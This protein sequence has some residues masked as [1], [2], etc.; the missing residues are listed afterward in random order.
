VGGNDDAIKQARKALDLDPNLLPGH[1]IL[2]QTYEVEGRL[3]EAI[4][5]YH[6][7]NEIEAT[8]SNYAML[9]YAYAKAGRLEETR[10]LVDKL[11]ELS[12]QRYVGAYPLAIVHLA[13]GE[14]DEA[15]RLLEQSFVERDILLQGLFGS[16]KIDKRLDPL[17][18]DP[19][20]Q[21]L[22]ERFDAG[23]PE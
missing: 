9:A 20:F 12:K 7:A 5:E 22:V 1:E 13:L 4:V 17:R 3:D 14:K 6:K 19:R 16:I 23:I 18:D 8:P 11:N 2:G 21:K 15:L 10:K